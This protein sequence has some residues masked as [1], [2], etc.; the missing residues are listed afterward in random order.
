MISSR[1]SIQICSNFA[2]TPAPEL[3]CVKPKINKLLRSGHARN[4]LWSVVEVV[5][6]PASLLLATPFFLDQLGESEYGIW[7]L[8]NSIIASIGVLNIGLGDATI[9]FVSKYR[10]QNQPAKI[11]LVVQTNYTIYQIGRAH[12]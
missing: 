2:A 3:F 8:A 6:Y 12:V 10:A 9:K 1:K 7:I 5:V 4:S 11:K